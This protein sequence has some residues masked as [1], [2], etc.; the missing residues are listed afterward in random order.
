MIPDIPLLPILLAG[1]GVVGLF[2]VVRSFAMPLSF[3]KKEKKKQEIRKV[4]EKTKALEKEALE[5]ENRT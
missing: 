4:M 1:L 3:E 2:V 5:K